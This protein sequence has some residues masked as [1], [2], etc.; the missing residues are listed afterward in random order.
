MSKGTLNKVMLIGRLGNDPEIRTTANG[1]AV[2]N[3]SLATNSG[4]KD[5]QTGEWR[6]TTE[7]HR[8]V[9]F[10][11]SAEVARDYLRKGSQVYIE[12]RLQTRK[13]QDQSGAERYTT[14][15]VGE[16]LEMLGGRGDA[17][18]GN[19]PTP[20]AQQSNYAPAAQN[21]GYAP[22]PQNTGAQPNYTPPP[23]N[24]NPTAP[25]VPTPPPANT[26]SNAPSGGSDS[27]DD[28]IPF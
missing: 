5:N 28:D 22:P 17:M 12:G 19:Y 13:W 18:G 11:R 26:T 4:Y 9:F 3:L 25:P 1:A 6:E 20:P 7:W 8:V 21:T 14:E 24:P 23:P 10:S 27:F 16:R 15:V 2:A